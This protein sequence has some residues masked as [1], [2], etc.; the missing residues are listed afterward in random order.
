MS[1]TDLER[2]KI[3]ERLISAK[4]DNEDYLLK[5]PE[6][7]KMMSAFYEQLLMDKPDDVFKYVIDHF[8]T[9]KK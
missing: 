6:V 8:S 3:E 2:F 1:L 5:H 9:I 4:I 7:Q